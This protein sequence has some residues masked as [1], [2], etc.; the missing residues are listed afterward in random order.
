MGQR[1]FLL[2]VHQRL[3]LKAT[4]ILYCAIC[5]VIVSCAPLSKPPLL[6]PDLSLYEQSLRALAKKN[7]IYIGAA[8]D[9]IALQTED[10]YR[11]ILNREFNMVT[12]ENAMKFESLHPRYDHYDFKAAD[13]MVDFAEAHGMKVRGHTLVWHKQLPKWLKG[14][15]WTQDELSTI[16]KEHITT[17]VEHYKGRVFAWDVVNEAVLSDG[18]LREN[19]WFDAIGADYIKMAFQWAHE[20]DPNVMLFY[21]DYGGEGLNQKSD[22]IYRLV[23]DMVYQGI[24]IH[25]VGLQMH[26]SIDEYPDPHDVYE[27]MERF[28]ALG[29]DVHITEMDVRIKIPVTEEGRGLQAH[30]YHDI[31]EACVS[32]DACKAFVLWGVSDQYSWIP[33]FFRGWDSGLIFDSSYNPKTA[34]KALTEA[35][36]IPKKI[37]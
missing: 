12:A 32:S 37:D 21:N 15:D 16:L 19:L 28:A 14:G 24:P 7:G 3:F 1:F 33:H 2:H 6:A 4:L 34:Y 11:Q 25:G 13:A 9:V 18:S 10:L 30:I 20:A 23:E 22:A 26:I 8:V 27:N 31:C 29:V 17:V 36:V 35:L 5:S